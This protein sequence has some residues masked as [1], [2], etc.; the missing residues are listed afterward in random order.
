MLLLLGQSHRTT[1]T[2]EQSD[3]KNCNY[4]QIDPKALPVPA[5]TPNHPPSQRG[6]QGEEEERQPE[7]KRRKPRRKWQVFPGRNRFFCDGRI[8][9][10]RKSGVLPLT[11]GLILVTTGLFFVFE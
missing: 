1:H 8:I 6:A 4:Q 11:L 10:A 3:M 5:P 9:L 7:N 2:G